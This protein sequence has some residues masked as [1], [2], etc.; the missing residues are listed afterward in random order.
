MIFANFTQFLILIT[1]KKT[2]RYLSIK[3]FLLILTLYAKYRELGGS[4]IIEEILDTDRIL[5][6]INEFSGT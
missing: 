1:T 5:L 6:K 4:N 2:H 3:M